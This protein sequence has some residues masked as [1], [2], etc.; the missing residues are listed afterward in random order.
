MSFRKHGNANSRLFFWGN[1][2]EEIPEKSLQTDPVVLF[3]A[4]Q[5]VKKNR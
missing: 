2:I 4:V 3:S 1:V 5:L